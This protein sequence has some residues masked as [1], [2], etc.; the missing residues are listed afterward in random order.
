MDDAREERGLLAPQSVWIAFA[1]EALVVQL[2]KKIEA[3]E[4]KGSS[5]ARKPGETRRFVVFTAL[6]S[7]FLHRAAR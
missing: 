3:M 1:V 6:V 2:D 5:K 4:R 7:F